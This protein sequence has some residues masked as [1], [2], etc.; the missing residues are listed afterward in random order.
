MTQNKNSFLL[1]TRGAWYPETKRILLVN[2]PTVSMSF[3]RVEKDTWPFVVLGAFVARRPWCPSFPSH[4][5]V[6]PSLP[7]GEGGRLEGK[8]TSQRQGLGS[9]ATPPARH[10]LHLLAR[11]A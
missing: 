7:G 3:K 2:V 10:S 6:G 5:A 8:A 4:R 11:V 9:G 1:Y